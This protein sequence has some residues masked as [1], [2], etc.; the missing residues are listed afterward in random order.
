[1]STDMGIFGIGGG[2]AQGRWGNVHVPMVGMPE[3]IM[4]DSMGGMQDGRYGYGRWE[5]DADGDALMMD[6]F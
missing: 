2:V 5:V 4:M 6:A 3:D 1:M